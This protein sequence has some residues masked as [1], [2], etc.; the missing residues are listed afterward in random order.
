MSGWTRSLL[1]CVALLAGAACQDQSPE[2]LLDDYL[3]RIRRVTSVET[4]LAPVQP[5]PPYPARRE[6]LIDIPRQTINVIEFFELHGCDMGALVGFRNSPLGRVQSPSQRLGYETAWI[7]AARA[8]DT[9]AAEWLPELGAV[10][11]EWLPSLFWNATFA[12]EELRVALGGSAPAR[13][14]GLPTL[15]RALADQLTKVE[16]GGFDADEL[17]RLLGQLRQSSW[18]GPARRDWQRWRRYLLAAAATLDAATAKVCLNRRPTPYTDRLKNVFLKVYIGHIQPD[19]AVAMSEHE[20]WI[21]E[22]GRLGERL[23]PVLPDAYRAWYRAVLAPEAPES[24]WQR[25]RAAV[26]RHARAWQRLF[27]HCH[28]EPVSGLSQD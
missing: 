24:E 27:T 20:Q 18:V 9:D 28:V 6:L 15:L 21:V 5:L 2:A 13:E 14:E 1:T 17:E 26:V 8:C 12:A 7:E 11:R 22:L 10:K 19:L 4:E 16:N 3:G 23:D 25:T